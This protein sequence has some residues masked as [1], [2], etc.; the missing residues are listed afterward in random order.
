VRTHRRVRLDLQNERQ[1]RATS[2]LIQAERMSAIG[3]KCSMPHDGRNLLAAIYG[4]AELLER[5]DRC[6]SVRAEESDLCH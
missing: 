6:A 3:S 1:W 4:N 5:H 2:H